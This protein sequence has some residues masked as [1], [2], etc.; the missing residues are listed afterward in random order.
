MEK[1]AKSIKYKDYLIKE[2]GSE[3]I[4]QEKYENI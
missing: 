3:E 2:H 4:A 1:I